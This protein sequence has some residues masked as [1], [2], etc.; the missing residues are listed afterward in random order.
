MGSGILSKIVCRGIEGK[1]TELLCIT[2]MVLV[3]ILY[4]FIRT[5]KTA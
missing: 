2:T 3:I 5:H 1:V 4:A